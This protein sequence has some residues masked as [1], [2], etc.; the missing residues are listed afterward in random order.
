MLDDAF[1]LSRA[2]RLPASRAI[3]AV[4]QYLFFL[5]SLAALNVLY[6]IYH[7]DVL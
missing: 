3:A 7:I 2:G 6:I 4:S 5:P 1:V